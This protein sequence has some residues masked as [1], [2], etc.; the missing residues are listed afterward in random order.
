MVVGASIQIF[1]YLH[2]NIL[3]FFLINS[4]LV[5]RFFKIMT[6]HRWQNLLIP[7]MSKKCKLL[8]ASKFTCRPLYAPNF[9][10]LWFI[11]SFCAQGSIN[12]IF[13]QKLYS[14]YEEASKTFLF[15]LYLKLFEHIS[16]KRITRRP[17]TT[18]IFYAF[19]FS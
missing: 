7:K 2:S 6:V 16:R 3:Q 1:K 11:C 8:E 18:G 13:V 14:K 17:A 9:S 10:T 5:F 19:P 4:H 12:W 15:P